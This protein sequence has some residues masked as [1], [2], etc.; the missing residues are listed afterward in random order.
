MANALQIHDC[1]A[2]VLSES[3]V[4]GYIFVIRGVPES[5]A[6][7]EITTKSI[8]VL[9]VHRFTPRQRCG[10]NQSMKTAVLIIPRMWF[11]IKRAWRR[12]QY[13]DTLFGLYTYVILNNFSAVGTE[14]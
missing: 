5:I 8:Y 12:K 2:K 13:T 1:K 11:T 4:C 3:E 14:I 6:N 9:P 10:G 7:A